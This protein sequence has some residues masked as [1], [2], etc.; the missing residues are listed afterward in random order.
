[1][2]GELRRLNIEWNRLVEAAR[3]RGIRRIEIPELGRAVRVTPRAHFQMSRTEARARVRRLQE[4]TAP[5]YAPDLSSV[6]GFRTFGIEIECIMPIDHSRHAV[7]HAILQAGI[8]CQDESLH[9]TTRSYWRVTHDGSVHGRGGH[10]IE[11]VSPALSGE[12]GFDQL[13]KVCQVLNTLGAKINATCGIHVHVGRTGS[14]PA[15]IRKL[16]KLQ[17]KYART[18]DAFLAPSRRPGGSG[19]C[20]PVQVQNPSLLE[21]AT[22]INEVAVAVGQLSVHDRYKTINLRSRAPTVEFR[23]HQGSTDAHKIEMWTRFCIRAME[24]VEVLTDNQIALAPAYLDDLMELIGATEAETN[25]FN[26]RTRWFAS[27]DTS[28]RRFA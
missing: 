20:K 7:A 8:M 1:M 21:T 12:A 5:F 10:G 9:H 2:M 16:M 18:I 17:V 15:G 27:G 22:T 13:R 23:Q 14:T 19:Y 28:T 25:Y 6:A 4:Q 3:E 26:E 24:R 11:I